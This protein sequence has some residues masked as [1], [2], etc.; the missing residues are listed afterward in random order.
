MG[1]NFAN[2]FDV[3][4]GAAE[5]DKL[6]QD[7]SYPIRAGYQETLRTVAAFACRPQ[8][9]RG[10]DL[11]SGTGNLARLLSGY[12]ELVCVD[13]AE[14]MHSAA[15]TKIGTSNAV[16]FVVAD[17][18]DYFASLPVHDVITST[19]AMHHL[20]ELE[21]QEL[22]RCIWRALN[23]GGV[24]IFGDLMFADAYTR[25]K[26]CERYMREGH[27]GVVEAIEQKHFWD[28][29]RATDMLH[30]IGFSVNSR[31]VAELSWVIVAEKPATK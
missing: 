5:Y 18:L 6:M 14:R 4:G 21:K 7:E 29:S 8:A 28:V 2:R 15:R 31:W 24:A 25:A 12:A 23:P 10:L 11:G 20:N 1:V 16:E 9:W 22:C 30:Q 19:Y 17:V 3:E 13:L 26:L 27:S